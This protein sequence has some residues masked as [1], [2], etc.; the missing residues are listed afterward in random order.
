MEKKYLDHKTKNTL[1]KFG[2]QKCL[3]EIQIQ[4]IYG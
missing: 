1:K 4:N 2:I 3:P